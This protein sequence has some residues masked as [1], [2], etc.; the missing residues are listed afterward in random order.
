[1][2]FHQLYG[3]TIIYILDLLTKVPFELNRSALT[4]DKKKDQL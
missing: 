2:V 3:Y 1:M 4:F